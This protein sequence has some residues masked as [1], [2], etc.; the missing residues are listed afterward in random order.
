M[1]ILDFIGNTPLMSIG[2]IY[3]KME[4][5]N[6]SG[7][8]KDRIAKEMLLPYISYSGATKRMGIGK[9][10]T[11]VEATS[12]N[13]GIS[14]AMVCAALGLKCWLICPV[15]TSP[16]KKELMRYYGAKIDTARDIKACMQRARNMIKFKRADVYPD[17]FSNLYNLEAQEKMAQEAYNQLTKEY[18]NMYL[19]SEFWDY[20]YHESLLPNAIVAGAGT[21]GTLM[22]LHK[23][24]PDADVYEVYATAEKPIEGITDCVE[25]PLIPKNLNK[26]RIAVSYERAVRTANMLM[27][28]YGISCGISSGANYYVSSI[29]AAHYDSVLTVFAD[30]RVRYL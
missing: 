12:G 7:S 17:Q 21:G 14:I 8:I 4:M 18:Q 3:F 27:K 19:G 25:Q 15:D 9:H 23:V 26:T 30:N 20:K 2:K 5:M 10:F 13:T 11:V 22:G 16:L 28:R 1:N 6:P 24:F 29:V